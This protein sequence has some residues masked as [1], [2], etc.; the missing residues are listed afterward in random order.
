M[1]FDLH[2]IEIELN[3]NDALLGARTRET[4]A[5]HRALA[6]HK[7][8][9]DIFFQLD[10]TESI[11]APPSGEPAYAERDLIH[12]YVT[13]PR[14]VAHF[15]RYGQLQIDL[16]HA[17]IEG[18]IIAA[19]LTTYGVF[20]DLVAIGLAPLLRRRG[21][22][23][24]H[25]FAAERNGR[26]ALLVGSIGAGKTTTGIALLRAGWRLLSNDSPLIDAVTSNILSY[27]GLLSAYPETLRRFPEL[28]PLVTDAYARRKISFAAESVY[29]DVWSG[30]AAPGVILFPTV[31]KI[32]EHRAV[33]LTAPETLRL[34][35]PHAV[36]RWDTEM[37]PQHLA[38]LNRVAAQTPAYQLLLAP[39]TETVPQ[40]LGKLLVSR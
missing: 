18:E 33:R 34:L 23:L 38:L 40:L 29:R 17:R 4:F 7:S 27:P 16:A 37:I 3:S 26:G 21:K 36:E 32:S 5:S 2:G 31:E 20:E 11:P 12:Y 24:V 15:P 35:L 28:H 30:A 19:A 13:P 25:A 22:F 39:D 1:R 9:P 10:L 14:V 8:R 6:Q